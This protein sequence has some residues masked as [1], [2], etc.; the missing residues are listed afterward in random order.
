M[1]TS[2]SVEVSLM[3]QQNWWSLSDK[4]IDINW[5]QANSKSQMEKRRKLSVMIGLIKIL[6]SHESVEESRRCYIENS[7]S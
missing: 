1:L 5:T 6:G 2:I 7:L 3:Y 4:C